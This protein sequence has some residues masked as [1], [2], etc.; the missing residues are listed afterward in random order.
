[1]CGGAGTSGFIVWLALLNDGMLNLK[2]HAARR[3]LETSNHPCRHPRGSQLPEGEGWPWQWR[4]PQPG[5][6][7][8]P[9]VAESIPFGFC[10]LWF[11]G[12][13]YLG[14]CAHAHVYVIFFV[15]ILTKTVF[16]FD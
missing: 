10:A 11:M 5:L 3:S 7:E 1:M 16:S 12:N 13:Q 14:M 2:V 9:E 4:K 15:G 8:E 6:I